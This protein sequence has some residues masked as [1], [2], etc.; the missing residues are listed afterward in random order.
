MSAVL[1]ET[2]SRISVA[3]VEDP[4]VVV[5]G[6]DG[7]RLVFQ[8]EELRERVLAA[9]ARVRGVVVDRILTEGRL[10]S[11]V[12]AVEVD[13][14]AADLAVRRGPDFGFVVEVGRFRLDGQSAKTPWLSYDLC[15]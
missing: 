9:I 6:A 8:R 2:S 12:R 14:E 1:R 3:E 13:A 4:C 11:A 15:A 5:A 10:L 7:D